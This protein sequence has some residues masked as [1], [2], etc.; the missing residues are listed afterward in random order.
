MKVLFIGDPHFKVDNIY[1]TKL[2]IRQCIRIIETNNF[3]FVTIGGDLLHTHERI[4][5]APLNLCYDFVQ[6]ISQLTKV[7]V[8]VGNHDFISN[9]QWCTQNHW[10][11]G[12][13]QWNNVT[14]V[15]YPLLQTFQNSNDDTTYQFIFTPYVPNGKFKETLQLLEEKEGKDYFK[16]VKLS[17]L[18][19]NLMDVTLV[20]ILYLKMATK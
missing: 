20:I 10:M 12:M 2:F 6:K 18:T 8:L 11:N 7:Y 4:H 14:I 15:D 9:Q 3:D 17:L 5:V 1:E 16:N 13:K 19:K